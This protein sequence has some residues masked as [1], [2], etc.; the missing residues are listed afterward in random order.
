MNLGEART[1]FGDRGFDGVLSSARMNFYL[2]RALT[3]FGD[4]YAWPWL[5]K[6]A[7]GAA[8]LTISDLK[9]V[10]SVYDSTGNEMFGLDVNEDVDLTTTGSPS[11]W[12]IDDTS[13]SAVITAYPVGTV[14]L[15]VSYVAEAPLLSADSD[16]PL[17]P[18]RY[19]M[20]WIDLAVMRAYRDSDNFA[21]ASALQQ[22]VN[23]D[24]ERLIE[25]Y[26]TRNR[27][28][29]GHILIRAGSEDGW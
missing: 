29:A 7:T 18:V 9:Y 24:L 6:T 10:R 20:T 26:E 13:G 11:Y 17:M 4:Y 12:W 2:N 15:R 19:H 8:P 1:E 23:A 16:V 21:A 27:M 14:T 25:R 3:D 28:N 22:V 5:R